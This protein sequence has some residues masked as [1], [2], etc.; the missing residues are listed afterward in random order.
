MTSLELTDKKEQLTLKAQ[1]LLNAG[2]AEQRKLTDEE[3]K[4]Y[5]SICKEIADIETELRDL[6]KELSNNKIE[7]KKENM[8]N[9]SLLKAI[10][11]VANNQTLDERS[12]E[13]INAGVEEMR[14][15]GVSYSGQIQIPT[16]LRADVQAT[17]DTAGKEVVA[18]DK[19]NILGP[20]YQNLV[21]SQANVKWMTN[22]T[23][24]LSIPNYSGSNCGWAGEVEAAKDGAGKFGE[25]ELSPKRLTAYLDISKQFLIQDSASA[26]QL[27]R[28][29][30]VRAIS[31]ELE[32]T[33]L[34]KEA[35]SNTKPAGLFNG[36]TAAT[37]TYDGLVDMEEKLDGVEAFQNPCYI[38][39]P[40]IKAK[41]RKAK[42]DAG[43][44]LF[45]YQNNEIN[46]IPCLCSS[47]CKGIVLGD[48]SNYVI[49]Q[50]GSAIDLTV[51]QY[52]QAANG[53]IR[54]VVNAYFDAAKLRDEAFVTGI[55]E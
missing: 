11:M 3:T 51:D 30:I 10:R 48:F 54:L 9:F 36:A 49:G 18:T 13:V 32:K 31:N 7:N 39:S 52:T 53:K 55:A 44:G 20:I 34:G 5:N 43:S 46:G 40:A 42:T 33:I 26:E 19:L 47:A 16:E 8:E 4:E 27:L 23:G 41:L 17:V 15:S 22:L 6:Q 2:K 1:N 38:V 35:G 25:I 24:T 14:K 29:D 50:W 21:L 37:L 12:Q 45:V 28:N